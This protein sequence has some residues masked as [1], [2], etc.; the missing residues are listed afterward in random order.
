MKAYLVAHGLPAADVVEDHA[1]FA[2]YDSC[3]RARAVFGVHDAIVVSQSY[4]LP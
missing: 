2:T 1:G 4:D 3:Y